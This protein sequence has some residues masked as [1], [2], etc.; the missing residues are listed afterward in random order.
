MEELDI[1]AQ[2]KIKPVAAFQ[3]ILFRL[4]STDSKF[5]RNPY[6][7]IESN[8]PLKMLFKAI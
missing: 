4:S 3:I 5:Q 7:F 8:P 1:L 2:M 6:G